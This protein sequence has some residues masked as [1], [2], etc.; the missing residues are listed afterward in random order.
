M[1]VFVGNL[2]LGAT[3]DDLITAFEPYGTVVSANVLM[4]SATG[5]NH[6]YGFV[7]MASEEEANAAISALNGADFLQRELTVLRR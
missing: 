7:E 4:N 1:R 2:D 6:G 3:D 5:E